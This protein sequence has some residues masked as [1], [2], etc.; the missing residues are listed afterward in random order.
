MFELYLKYEGV[1]VLSFFLLGW[2]F[3]H[4]FLWLIIFR[5]LTRSSNVLFL[6]YNRRLHKLE[7]SDRLPLLALTF[8]R[9]VHHS[10]LQFR[11]SQA[12]LREV[13]QVEHKLL[14]AHCVRYSEMEPLLVAPRVGV[15][16]HVH[17]VVCRVNPVCL[18]K[19]TRLKETIK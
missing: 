3:L 15:N 4:R 17:L 7:L 16:L 19:I 6:S 10:M 13:H 12:W 5:L 18:Q 9:V 2:F 1:V 11:A 8:G 14:L